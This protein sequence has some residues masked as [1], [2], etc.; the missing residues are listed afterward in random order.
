MR[1]RVSTWGLVSGLTFFC[2]DSLDS[3]IFLL[4]WN[5]MVGLLMSFSTALRSLGDMVGTVLWFKTSPEISNRDIVGSTL[6]E[7]TVPSHTDVVRLGGA[8]LLIGMGAVSLGGGRG[9]RLLPSFFLSTYCCSSLNDNALISCPFMRI[10]RLPK[11]RQTP[12]VFMNGVPIMQ[13][14]QS[15]FTRSR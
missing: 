7:S 12:Y 10:V 3:L 15:I 8:V 9:P 5:P 13:S 1:L 6:V 4:A 2:A 11:L 14:Y